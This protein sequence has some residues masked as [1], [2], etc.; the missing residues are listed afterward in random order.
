M[1]I[2]FLATGWPDRGSQIVGTTRNG[3]TKPVQSL[4]LMASLITLQTW[5]LSFEAKVF[6]TMVSTFS[7]YSRFLPLSRIILTSIVLDGLSGWKT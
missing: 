4:V 2:P 1:P 3:R 5:I 6:V 7:T